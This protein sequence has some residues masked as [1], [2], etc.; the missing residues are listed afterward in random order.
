LLRRI[1][2]F[3]QSHERV[4]V[5]LFFLIGLVV[6]VWFR[7]GYFVYAWDTTYPVN[8]AAY[9]ANFAN[10]WR[11]INSTGFSDANGLPFLPYFA[12]VYFLQDVVALPLVIAEAVLFYLL[13]VISG[14]SMYI[15][16]HEFLQGVIES[17]Q[18]RVISLLSGAFYMINLYTLYYIWR[19]FTVEAFLLAFFPLVAF[20]TWKGLA[21]ARTLGKIDIPGIGRIVLLSFLI[22]PAFTNPAFLLTGAAFLSLLIVY[23]LWQ[24]PL[25]RK[26]LFRQAGFATLAL[27]FWALSNL[28]WILPQLAN[29]GVVLSRLGPDWADLQSNS[30]HSP[31]QNVLRLQGLP[32]LYQQVPGAIVYWFNSLYRNAPL[33]IAISILI[34]IVSFA[35]LT[36]VSPAG[37]RAMFI[38]IVSATFMFA[39]EGLN[40]PFGSIF[41]WLYG[42]FSFMV[43][44]RDPYQKIGWIIPLTY[45]LLFSLGVLRIYDLIKVSKVRNHARIIR[46]VRLFVPVVLVVLVMGVYC[47]PFFTGDIILPGANVAIPTYYYSADTFLASK[48]GAFRILSL[49]LDR[50]LQGSIWDHGYVGNDLLRATSGEEV[51][52]TLTPDQNV[53]DLLNN[54]MTLLEQNNTFVANLLGVLNVK[55]VVIRNDANLNY[56]LLGTSPS[57]FTSE[58][59]NQVGL[60]YSATFGKLD[61]YQNNQFGPRIYAVTNLT[62]AGSLTNPRGVGWALTNYTGSWH[63]NDANAT[64]SSSSA[65]LAFSFTPDTTNSYAYFYNV[66]PL[67]VS[68]G[69]YPNL[70]LTFR[71][72]DQAMLSVNVVS[73]LG[74][75]YFL[76]ASNPPAVSLGTAYSSP[77]SYTLL[78]SLGK[79]FKPSDAISEIYVNVTP[80]SPSHSEMLSANLSDL[81]LTSYVGTNLDTARLIASSSFNW[82][83]GAIAETSPQES[84]SGS[85]P[86]IGFQELGPS[87]YRVSVTNATSPFLLV[88]DETFDYNWQVFPG[89]SH[90]GAPIAANHLRVNGYANGWVIKVPG[91]YSVTIFYGL[92]NYV[93]FGSYVSIATILMLVSM[94]L[95]TALK[96]SRIQQPPPQE[97]GFDQTP[98]KH[99][100]NDGPSQS[101]LIH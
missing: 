99:A 10:V 42:H 61:F 87:E 73:R 100:D 6:V 64:L 97:V 4:D 21:K 66:D 85:P 45:S 27:T 98:R 76:Y 7:Q 19:I 65:G 47:W 44:F 78:F 63:T 92:Q 93:D 67:N 68:I 24:R 2:W 77:Q 14:I 34:P 82:T 70:L 46:S 41:G 88:F 20:E 15:F 43:A 57:T 28:W 80:M 5:I 101:S 17:K 58:I 96:K 53:T 30:I 69:T 56:S 54:A 55:Y 40:P 39:A 86:G 89:S 33:F 32:P 74:A 31:L 71:T 1:L 36:R 52:S 12:V 48:P 83:N 16:A 75:S 94:T 49:P 60:S 81:E 29:T 18:L 95:I 3:L 13:F 37:R 90:Y 25:T 62:S 22:L 23:G 91:T 35:S 9:L 59:E 11:S 50:V 8:A 79:Y 38:A 72:S 51:I 84:L 26:S